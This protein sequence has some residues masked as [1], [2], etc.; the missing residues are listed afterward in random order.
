MS[1]ALP[2]RIL[3]CPYFLVDDLLH[4]E[5]G[6][7]K[8]CEISRSEPFIYEDAVSAAPTRVP[9]CCKLMLT[10]REVEQMPP[11]KSESGTDGIEK[12][13]D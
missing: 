1:Q 12:G 6:S 8:A 9:L 3:Q 2:V 13:R 11:R 7:L 10:S 5:T 4:A